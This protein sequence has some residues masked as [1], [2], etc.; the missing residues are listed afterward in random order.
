MP[1]GFKWPQRIARAYQKFCSPSMY[2]L[3]RFANLMDCYQGDRYSFERACFTS[4]ERASTGSVS[5]GSP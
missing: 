5:K 4:V 3:N 1:F 2:L